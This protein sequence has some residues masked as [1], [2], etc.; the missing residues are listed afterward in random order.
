MHSLSYPIALVPAVAF[1]AHG[2]LRP[3]EALRAD[4]RLLTTLEEAAAFAEEG[5]RYEGGA[6]TEE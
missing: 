4:L 1:R 5:K 6:A 2:A 3:H